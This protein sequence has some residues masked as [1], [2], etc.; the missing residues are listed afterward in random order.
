MNLK[1]LLLGSSLFT[2]FFGLSEL[3]LITRYNLVLGIPD[4][5]FICTSSIV[6]VTIAELTSIP[7]LVYA[8]RICPK[9]LEGTMYALITSVSNFGGIMGSLLGGWM[10]NM[11]GITATSIFFEFRFFKFIFNELNFKWIRYFPTNFIKMD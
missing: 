9:N 5:I 4:K 3:L 11:L 1:K 2:C 6:I 10:T 8:S 7:L